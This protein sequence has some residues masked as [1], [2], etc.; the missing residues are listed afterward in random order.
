MTE[1]ISIVQQ[2]GGCG[3]T[4]TA[5]NLATSITTKQKKVLLID[6]D[7]QAC[8]TEWSNKNSE[9]HFPTIQCSNGKQIELLID[10]GNYDYVVIDGAPRMESELASIIKI[11]DL[12]IMPCQPSPLDIWAC[13]NVVEMIKTRQNLCDLK[14]VFLLNGVHPLSNLQADILEE[15]KKYD[16]PMLDTVIVARASYRRIMLQG[17]SVI[18]SEDE[19][20]SGEFQKLTNE[21]LGVLHD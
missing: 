3:K 17:K 21:I 9:Y 13:A 15:M 16:I 18:H 5:T 20:A 7:P 19:K 1:V 2:K 10:E 4:T 14:A 12:V 8:A 6:A 11:S